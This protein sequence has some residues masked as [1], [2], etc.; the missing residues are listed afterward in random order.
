MVEAPAEATRLISDDPLLSDLDDDIISLD[1]GGIRN[2]KK[3][4]DAQKREI[5][6]YA[7]S[8]GM[9]RNKIICLDHTPTEY[10]A[11]WD[12]LVIGTDALPNPNGTR[13]N[14]L[15]S[16]RGCMAHEIIGHRETCFL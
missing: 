8:L 14:S 6:D 12:M 16:Y 7:V 2:S 10:N 4:T 1:T 15:I 9:P 3:L 11:A 13:A 5:T